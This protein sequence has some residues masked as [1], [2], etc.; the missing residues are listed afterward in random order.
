MTADEA[1]FHEP[2]DSIDVPEPV[3]ES[4][5][6]AGSD[7]IAE[8]IV[9][10]ERAYERELEN[11]HKAES[12]AAADQ[13]AE[14]PALEAAAEPMEQETVPEPLADVAEAV[15]SEPVAEATEV[16]PQDDAA[17][18]APAPQRSR[19]AALVER[20]ANNDDLY[21]PLTSADD[22]LPVGRRQSGALQGNRPWLRA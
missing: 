6:C 7:P 15:E 17:I 5:I 2:D 11:W 9:S 16:L 10:D 13:P 18:E 1:A 21:T 19:L 8:V 4:G 3:A 22:D 12:E 14:E 20:L